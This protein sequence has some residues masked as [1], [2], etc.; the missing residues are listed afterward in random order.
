MF[1]GYLGLMKGLPHEFCHPF[2]TVEYTWMLIATRCLPYM[3]A[4]KYAWGYAKTYVAVV[5]V[6]L[7]STA[8]MFGLDV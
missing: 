6:S 8:S 4:D 7:P 3:H 1:A 2:A 5:V